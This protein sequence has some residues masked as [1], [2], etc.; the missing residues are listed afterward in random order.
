MGN[1]LNE[2]QNTFNTQN[3]LEVKT[4][5]QKEKQWGKIKGFMDT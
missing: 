4:K 2:I 3:V 5:Y 1:G